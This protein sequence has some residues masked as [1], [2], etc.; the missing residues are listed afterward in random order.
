MSLIWGDDDIT[1]DTNNLM[2][3]FDPADSYGHD[4]IGNPG[5]SMQNWLSCCIFYTKWRNSG[6]FKGYII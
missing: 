1:M 4:I 5:V 6:E 3:N 2:G